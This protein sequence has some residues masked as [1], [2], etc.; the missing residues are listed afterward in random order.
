MYYKRRDLYVIQGKDK[1]G[2]QGERA[3]G[4]YLERGEKGNKIE[5]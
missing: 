2:L 3:K 1:T 5:K 4:A